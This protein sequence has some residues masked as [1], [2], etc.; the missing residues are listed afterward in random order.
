M[1]V[2]KIISIVLILIWISSS[3]KESYP[4]SDEVWVPTLMLAPIPGPLQP[5]T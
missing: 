4:S 5:P 3:L 1:Q 2:L